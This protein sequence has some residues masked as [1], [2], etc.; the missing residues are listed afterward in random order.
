MSKRIEEPQQSAENILPI[1]QVSEKKVKSFIKKDKIKSLTKDA[2]VYHIIWRDAFS[3]T[4]E[5]HD[6]SSIEREDY[7]C[8]TVG[9]LIS[10]NGKSNYYTIAST[11]TIDNYFCMVINIPKAMV[12]SK[13]K[14][15]FSR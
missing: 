4:D 11:V 8:H 10:D 6:S 7:I 9:Y 15:N 12:I 13:E 2:P 1:E 3:E 14:I 5:W